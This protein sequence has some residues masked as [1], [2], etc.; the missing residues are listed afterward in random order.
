MGAGKTRG[1][2][3]IMRKVFGK[4]KRYMR[5][6]ILAP[7]SVLFNWQEEILKWS[8][9][10]EKR[11]HVITGTGAAR[12]KKIQKAARGENIIIINWEAIINKNVLKSLTDF[13]PEF[14]VGDELHYIKSYK[15]KRS[16][17][18]VLLGNA[19]RS[20]NGYV[21]GLT[22]TPILN[23]PEDIFMQFKFLDGGGIFGENFFSFRK[24]YMVNVNAGWTGPNSFEK[25]VPNQRLFE[26]LYKKIGLL[27]SRVTKED[28]L[29]DLPPLIKI[30]RTVELGTKQRKAY[31]EMEKEFITYLEGTEAPAVATLAITKALRLMEIISGYVRT[32]EGEVI[33]FDDNPRLKA[34]EDLLI[35]ITASEKVIVWAC[36]RQNYL[37]IEKLCQ[38]LK[39]GYVK[40]VGEMSVEEKQENMNKFRSDPDCKVVV[41]SRKAAG[42]GINLIEAKYSVVY[43]RNFSLADELQSEARNYR[44]GSQ[45]HDQVVKINLMGKDTID[46]RVTQA[47]EDKQS[48]SDH[49]IDWR[50]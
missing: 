18:A 32:D 25:W 37:Q 34:L 22:G 2:V 38:K 23:S 36:W 1:T 26:Q 21:I 3:E 41:G 39:L 33:E 30:P 43:S 42:T 8:K 11:I 31:L 35:E 46:E 19:A 50:F 7:S 28:C 15:S 24:R 5:T 17:A 16:K 29:K 45:M 27:A 48:I 47:L 14:I 40:L 49:I 12:V 13:I 6:I 20:V 44:G 4:N 10:D 9:M